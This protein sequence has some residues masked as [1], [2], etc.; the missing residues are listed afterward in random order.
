MPE[1][2]KNTKMTVLCNDCLKRSSVPFHILPGK[3]QHCRSYNT[4]KTNEDLT[5]NPPEEIENNEKKEN[6]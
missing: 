5:K 4:T 1:E 6:N 2:Y 3:C